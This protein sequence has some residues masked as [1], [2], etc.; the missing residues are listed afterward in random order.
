MCKE[1]PM[2][3]QLD[4][5]WCGYWELIGT[6]F[7]KNRNGVG[8]FKMILN[9]LCHAINDMYVDSWFQKDAITCHIINDTRKLLQA[10]FNNRIISL[11]DDV[12]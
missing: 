6:Y 1:L 10:R 11:Q 7:F 5:V 8:S 4:I 9:F 2:H 3:S 12:N